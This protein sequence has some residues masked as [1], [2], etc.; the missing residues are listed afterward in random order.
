MKNTILKI[1]SIGLL[2]T[3]LF[4]S[5]SATGDTQ[6]ATQ[7]WTSTNFGK[8]QWIQ[9]LIGSIP[10]GDRGKQGLGM[11]LYKVGDKYPANAKEPIGVVFYV[12][13]FPD[14]KNRPDEGL[15]GIVAALKDETGKFPFAP[16]PFYHTTNTT[17][18]LFSGKWNTDKLV[19]INGRNKGVVYAAEACAD[20]REFVRDANGELILISGWGLPSI[21]ELKFMY[22]LKDTI[23]NF[24]THCLYWSSTAVDNVVICINF[25]DGSQIGDTLHNGSKC[26][27]RAVLAF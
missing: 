25:D 16:V 18:E 24:N 22:K 1:L 10:K 12:H 4:D 23:G 6:P 21:R 7:E 20:H 3:G 26:A 13:D 5:V 27:V 8:I 17:A 15:H 11:T 9:D 14:P 19:S 2:I